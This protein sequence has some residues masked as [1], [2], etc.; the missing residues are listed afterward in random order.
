[1]QRVLWAAL[2]IVFVLTYRPVC[3][4]WV[5]DWIRDPNYNHGFLIPLIS[6]Y[7][8]W[9]K[10]HQLRASTQRVS[11]IGVLALVAAAGLL[12]LGTAGAEV[13]TQRVSFVLMLGALALI[14][15]GW[16]LARIAAFPIALLLLAIPLPY[17][18]YY[19]LTSPMQALAAK[20]AIVGINAVGVP[21][22]KQGNVIHLAGTSLEVADACS[23][24]RSLYSFLTI[25]AL[26]AY[27]TPIPAWGR[28]FLFLTA[29]P[30]AVV[31]NAVRVWG[32]SLGVH[33]VG[34]EFA[35][36]TVHE[37]FGFLIIGV[38]LLVFL[39][40]RAGVRKLWSHDSSSPS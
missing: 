34:I 15:G 10:R 1:M 16:P 26:A 36:G 24:I 6:G 25:G 17:V 4:E 12:V 9:S 21:A 33:A 39:A 30:L 13:F 20:V 35:E 2:T 3:V 11:W 28:L 37:A 31:G 32:T 19:A 22:V 7:L 5:R 40:F 38:S 23:G 14:F 8:L 18:I 29:I 27:F